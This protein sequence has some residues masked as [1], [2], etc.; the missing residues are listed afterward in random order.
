MK[1]TILFV[2]DGCEPSY[3]TPQSAPN[4]H[5][6]V[7]ENGGFHKTVQ[8]AIP[9]VTN[10][11]HAAILSGL[12]PK[13]TMV[14]GN[15]YYDRN[16]GIQD[17][18]EAGVFMKAPTIFTKYRQAGKKTALLTVKGKVL[19]TFGK[20]VDY[21]VSA[22]HPDPAMLT[23][24]DLPNPPS[25]QTSEANFWILQ[26]AYQCVLRTDADFIYCTTND[27]PMHRYRPD[28]QESLSHIAGLDRLIGMIHRAAPDRAL[29]VTADHGMAQKTTVVDMNR[30]LGNL[31]Y[32][33]VCIPP[34]KDRYIENHLYQEGGMLYLFLNDF[35]ETDRLLRELAGQPSVEKV[36]SA[37]EAAD[38]YDLPIGA[39][40]DYV[41]FS[42]PEYAFG[43]LDQEILHTGDVRTHGSL[44]EREVP[45]FAVNPDAPAG[46]YR[47]SRDITP[48]IVV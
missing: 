17:F 13:D 6:M 46:E 40:G 21:G 36:L 19:K 37:R 5:R 14:A 3:L 27:F 8:G 24:L 16:T 45:L 43:E 30:I 35:S 42:A 2:I 34:I 22:E 26:A 44:Y 39:I 32:H 41:L 25:I 10:V 20:D 18:I 29:Y 48:R 28:S 9:S 31:G 15:Y 38:L 1:K 23:L 4:L 7:Q 47:Y 33:T 12:P 11:N